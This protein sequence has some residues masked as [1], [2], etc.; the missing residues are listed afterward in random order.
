MRSGPLGSGHEGAGHSTND[1]AHGGA[2]AVAVSASSR[3]SSPSRP[4]SRQAMDAAVR[5]SSD[6]GSCRASATSFASRLMARTVRIATGANARWLR[7]G[8]TRRVELALPACVRPWINLHAYGNGRCTERCEHYPTPLALGRGR[9]LST[10]TVRRIAVARSSERG[11][12]WRVLVAHAR[13]DAICLPP[14][15]SP[16]PGEGR[17]ELREKGRGACRS[18][19]LGNT[20]DDQRSSK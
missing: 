2:S 11:S 12:S 15:L 9:R 17:R 8:Q 4:S 18:S 19:P 7:G 13:A 14:G 6:V 5:A 10:G 3:S 1:G 20:G 16:R